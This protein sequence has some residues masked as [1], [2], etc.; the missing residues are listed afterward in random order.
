M[1]ASTLRAFK[2]RFSYDIVGCNFAT[3]GPP[4][5]NMMKRFS[6]LACLFALVLV[7]TACST[8]QAAT[9]QPTAQPTAFPTAVPTAAPTYTPQPTATPEPLPKVTIYYDD[10]AQVELIS[11]EGVR[12]LIDIYHPTGLSSPAV[13]T[14]ILLTTHTHHDHVIRSFYESFP[15]QQLFMSAGEIEAEGV[16]ILGIT[17]AHNSFDEIDLTKVSDPKKITNYIYIVD[18][19]GLRIVHFGDIGQ[20]ALTEEQLAAIGEVDVAITQFHNPASNMNVDNRKGYNLMEQVKPHIIIPTHNNNEASEYAT[21]IWNCVYTDRL[22]ISVGPE[23]IPEE[24]TLVFIGKLATAYQKI[25]G[26]EKADW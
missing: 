26:L 17:S 6:S 2:K 10:N 22:F 4:G 21:T 9:S 3:Q 1:R 5:E 8:P 18:M 24:T 25:Y 16:H 14:D 12:V 13:D 11:P 20:D 15:G 7:L 23:D 19:G